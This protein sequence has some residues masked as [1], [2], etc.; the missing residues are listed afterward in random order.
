M[1]HA[2]GATALV[3]VP[4]LT[5]EPAAEQALRRRVLEGSGLDY[6]LVPVDRRWRIQGDRHPDA[7]GARAIAEAVSAWLVAHDPRI[8]AAAAR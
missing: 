1:A 7:R 4:V 8:A 5:P 6:L 2:R 3:V